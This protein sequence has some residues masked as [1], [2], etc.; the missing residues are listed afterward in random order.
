MKLKNFSKYEFLEDG[1]VLSKT[2]R[3]LKGKTIGRRN[4]LHLISDD[5]KDHYKTRA[6]WILMTFTD[7]SEWKDEV[8]HIN[9]DCSDDRLCNLTWMKKNEHSKHHFGKI[10]CVNL[11][12][13]ESMVFENESDAST[14]LNIPTQE[15]SRVILGQ[16]KHTH[17]Y[18]FTKIG[19]GVSP[20][21]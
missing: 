14:K 9:H 4:F 6:R 18:W 10:V 21:S 11:N 1:T 13:D 15:I 8:H 7:E 12:N 5:N 2:N 17:D 16:R 20:T 19:L 3:P